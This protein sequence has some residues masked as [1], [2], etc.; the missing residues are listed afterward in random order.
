MDM[1]FF[2]DTAG[3]RK[4]KNRPHGRLPKEY[5]L[6]PMM[7]SVKDYVET[8]S[9][10]REVEAISLG[11]GLSDLAG[12]NHGFHVH[13]PRSGPAVRRPSESGT[14]TVTQKG[15][16]RPMT[17][18]HAPRTAVLV[19]A[20]L[21]LPVAAQGQARVEEGAACEVY[22]DCALRVRHRLLA[23]E[24]VRGAADIPVAEIGWGAPPIEALFARSDRAALSFDCLAA[25][26]ETS[27]EVPILMSAT[28]LTGISPD[29][30]VG[31]SDA[32][33]VVVAG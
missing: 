17:H 3:I 7:D 11:G 32:S 33:P 5:K 12:P 10:Y 24:I 2:K 1:R 27:A 18:P 31:V 8:L 19:L 29:C 26:F 15:D 9:K 21:G 13:G 6:D 30:A 16:P 20:L 28:T 4:R 22:E 23:T 25:G 14:G